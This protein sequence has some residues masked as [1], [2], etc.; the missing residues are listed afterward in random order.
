M[1]ENDYYT[2]ASII[3]TE[4]TQTVYCFM[5]SSATDNSAVIQ[6]ISM[7]NAISS[8]LYPADP[9]SRCQA[10]SHMCRERFWSKALNYMFHPSVIKTDVSIKI[11]FPKHPCKH[12]YRLMFRRDTSV[13]RSMMIQGKSCNR[14]SSGECRSTGT[15]P[16]ESTWLRLT[17]LVQKKKR[18]NRWTLRQ[19][20][21]SI[22]LYLELT[23][24]SRWVSMPCPCRYLSAR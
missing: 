9:V 23:S 6:Y 13:H 3:W 4:I 7:H 2:I 14:R 17:R 5:N 19:N 20:V 18:S 1:N 8:K 24:Q 12:T 21:W 16:K 22:Q 15:T 11:I 10:L